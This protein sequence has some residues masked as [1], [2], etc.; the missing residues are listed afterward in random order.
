MF[1]MVAVW[2][3]AGCRRDAA[4]TPALESNVVAV[5]SGTPIFAETL[6]SEIS[7]R[8]GT[9]VGGVTQARRM[10]A[11]EAL[12]RKEALYAKAV[13]A[14]FDRKPEIQSRIRNLVAERFA[15]GAFAVV[16]EPVSDAAVSNVYASDRAKFTVPAAV[17][18]SA[19]FVNVPTKATAEA[20][21]VSEEKV[22]R[23]LAEAKSA[24]AAFGALATR[25]S[26]DQA[27]RYRGGDLGWITLGTDDADTALVAELRK[28][29]KPGEIGGPVPTDRGFQIVQVTEL[30]PEA[31]RPLAEVRERIRHELIRQ[32]AGEAERR[33][34]LAIRQGLEIQVFRDRVEAVATPAEGPRPPAGPGGTRAE[35]SKTVSQQ[36]SE[37]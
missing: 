31:V 3:V 5:V 25:V 28:L 10:E 13:A 27:T 26:E 18:Y 16:A 37:Q 6:A 1:M 11:L 36:V 22:A 8:F 20:R 23:L 15:D 7:Q 29:T 35:I 30:R 33:N 12:I 17:R 2:L 14:G 19:I 24:P 9:P 32:S 21:T 34:E 4:I